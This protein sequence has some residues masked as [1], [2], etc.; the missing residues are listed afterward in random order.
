M[1]DDRP[2]ADEDFAAGS[3]ARVERSKQDAGVVTLAY[4]RF[5]TLVPQYADCRPIYAR[6]LPDA[7]G[8]RVV[9][10]EPLQGD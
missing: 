10:M 9:E 5:H 3:I 8:F 2:Q 4:E 1:S 7:A 6:E